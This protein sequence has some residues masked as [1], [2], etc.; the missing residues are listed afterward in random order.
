M[1]PALLIAP[2]R[3][4]PCGAAP[5]YPGRP[6][7]SDGAVYDV[8]AGGDAHTISPFA[9]GLLGDVW[10][11]YRDSNGTPW[12]AVQSAMY[13]ITGGGDFSG[14]TPHATGGNLIVGI[15]EHESML[16]ASWHGWQTVHD[17]SAGGNIAQAP[18]LADVDYTNAMRTV[19]EVGLLIA[20]TQAARV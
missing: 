15:A 9:F 10:A 8:A 7:A 4:A 13:D 20:T 2:E 14:A 11:L 18:V 1:L 6:A 17:F 19:P 12:A 5:R 16:L 3:S